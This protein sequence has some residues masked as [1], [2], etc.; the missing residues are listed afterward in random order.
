MTTF[1]LGNRARILIVDDHPLVRE[2]LRA[3]ISSQSDME[4][5]GDAGDIVTALALIEREKPD[6]VVI[7][8]SLERGNGLDLIV[9]L[10]QHACTAR[11]LVLSAYDDTLYAER[12]LKAGANGYINKGEARGKVLDALRIVL[13]G[14]TYL[15]PAL[16]GRLIGRALGRNE[17]QSRSLV[18]PLSNRELQVFEM[19]GRGRSVK[20]IAAELKL[21]SHTVNR[22][23][24]NIKA[25]LNLADAPALQLAAMQW[26][27]APDRDAR[28]QP[29]M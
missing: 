8:I 11:I 10:K 12:S 13:K 14:E 23:R 1:G 2:G 15:T 5:C 24:E 18:S 29:A 6:L 7:D 21:S 9:R 17:R 20:S 16:N 19:I 22:H 27:L 26:M 28:D 25:K 3:R 4:V